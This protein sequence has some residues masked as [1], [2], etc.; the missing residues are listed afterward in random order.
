VSG[1]ES[2]LGVDDAAGRKDV[3]G[4]DIPTGFDDW[5]HLSRKRPKRPY[6]QNPPNGWDTTALAAEGADDPGNPRV[7]LLAGTPV[8]TES[9]ACIE[10]CNDY[11]RMGRV[12][13][14][15]GLAR[16][17]EA[18]PKLAIF[19]KRQINYARALYR[20]EER[21]ALYDRET[22]RQLNLEA[23][24]ALNTGLALAHERVKELKRIYEALRAKMLT[25]DD[26][27]AEATPDPTA[28][29]PAADEKKTTRPPKEKINLFVVKEMRDTLADLAAET[30]GRQ[31]TL[32]LL[33]KKDPLEDFFLSL[34]V[35]QTPQ[36]ESGEDDNATDSTGAIDAEF[37]TVG[38]GT[39][40]RQPDGGP[41]VSE[42]DRPGSGSGAVPLPGE[43]NGSAPESD[44][45]GGAAGTPQEESN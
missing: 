15:N 32:T 4:A 25:Q 44:S 23:Q 10:A 41:D 18:N 20:W 13:T 43:C 17:Y 7:P 3:D 40:D 29:P 42:S 16:W 21:A 27:P 2:R 38:E 14:I 12:R 33:G 35:V 36:L 39:D 22:E 5:R 34:Q 30:G 6:L 8:P 19:G 28:V 31:K 9:R 1:S 45:F 11:L 24:E 26:P 37:T